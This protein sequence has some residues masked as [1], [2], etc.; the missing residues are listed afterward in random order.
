[1]KYVE[2][3]RAR[4]AHGCHILGRPNS[5]HYIMVDDVKPAGINR[6]KGTSISTTTIVEFKPDNLQVWLCI[7]EI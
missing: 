6:Y 3:L 4:N 2:W 5:T 1:M 7:S